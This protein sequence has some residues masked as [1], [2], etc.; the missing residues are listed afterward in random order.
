LRIVASLTYARPVD[1]ADLRD[2]VDFEE[3]GV[4][5]R[6][7]FESERLW[8]QVLSLDRNASYGPVGDQRADAVLTIV[9]GEAVFIVDKRRRRMKQWGSVLVPRGSEVVVTNA[10]TEPL[11]VLMTASPPPAERSD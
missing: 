1:A 7:V 2:F 5:R 4:V 8:V 3:G 10:S 6:T 11:V 9:A